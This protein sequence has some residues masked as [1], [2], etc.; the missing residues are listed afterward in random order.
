MK[1]M[2]VSVPKECTWKMSLWVNIFEKNAKY[3]VMPRGNANTTF[4]KVKLESIKLTEWNI[5]SVLNSKQH[6]Y[7]SSYQSLQ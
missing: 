2:H 4:A 3:K 7:I 1:N 6:L 5:K